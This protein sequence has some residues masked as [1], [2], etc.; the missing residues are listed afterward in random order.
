MVRQS[1]NPANEEGRIYTLAQ[2]GTEVK[3]KRALILIGKGSDMSVK[4]YGQRKGKKKTITQALVIKMIE[5]AEKEG[6]PEILKSLWNTYYCQDRVYTHEGRLYGK[7]CMNRFCTTCLGIRK[8]EMINTY[9]PILKNW[10]NAYMVTLTIKS[11]PKKDLIRILRHCIKGLTRIID[12]YEKREAR[13]TGKKL[14]GIRSLE[15]N[16]NPVKRTYNPHFHFIVP[17]FETAEILKSEWLRLWTLRPTNKKWVDPRAQDIK[18]VFNM[19]SAL[20]EVIKYGAKVFTDPTENKN[21]QNRNLK[22]YAR[23]FYN[24]ML[25]MK[26]LRL[27]ASF[28][29]KLPKDSKPERLPPRVTTDYEEWRYLPEFKDWQHTENELTLFGNMQDAYLEEVL[30]NCIDVLAE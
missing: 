9:Y 26:G 21:K 11:I 16:F 20:V 12:K 10:G 13:G 18:K 17:D 1:Q 8:A 5:I 29:F 15:C 2:N 22:V 3:D 30:V 28:G 27:F 6:R 23:A 14:I 19:D 7:Y 25:A 24:I 4:D